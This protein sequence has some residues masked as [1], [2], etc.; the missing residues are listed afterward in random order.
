MEQ[1]P[2]CGCKVGGVGCR[3]GE[4]AAIFLSIFLSTH[5]HIMIAPWDFDRAWLLALNFD[6]GALLD[7]VMYYAS[8]TWL[9]IPFYIFIVWH[10]YRRVGVSGVVAFVVMAAL[11][12]LCA[13]QTAGLFKSI[14]P[15][16]RPTH[17][18]PISSSVHTV[19]GY[20]GGSFG[21]VSSHA[22]NCMA[23]LILAGGVISRSWAW[24]L[25]SFW[26]VLVAYSRI[27][28]GVHYPM[29][30]AFGLLT[31]VVWGLV[32]RRFYRWFYKRYLIKR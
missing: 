16:L 25:L 15:K 28:L 5:E 6:G 14:L 4:G 29:D 22:A 12:I 13:D 11:M 17:Y 31:G 21:T 1:L 23:F 19:Y 27:Y 2:P 3:I 7:F 32:W 9:W 30:I 24:W 10:V 20:Q 26:V 8:T 18:D